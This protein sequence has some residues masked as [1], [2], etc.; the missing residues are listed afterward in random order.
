VALT[1]V[2]YGH[3]EHTYLAPT[4]LASLTGYLAT[5]GVVLLAVMD[6]VLVVFRVR[7]GYIPWDA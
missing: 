3:R 5:F 2:K 4:Q 1:R 6:T 7:L